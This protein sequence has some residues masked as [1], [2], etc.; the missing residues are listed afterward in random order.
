MIECEIIVLL[1]LRGDPIS[2]H[3]YKI[4]QCKVSGSAS[5][6]RLHCLA[7]GNDAAGPNGLKYGLKLEHSETCM[8][9][10]SNPYS[11]PLKEFLSVL[12]SLFVCF[13]I[14]LNYLSI[15]LSYGATNRFND[16][17]QHK[18]LSYPY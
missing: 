4:V 1:E 8:N 18:I 3:K 5:D 2:I 7:R 13:Q 11:N 16:L 15:H 9:I 12:L 6:E 10:G 17:Q 14:S